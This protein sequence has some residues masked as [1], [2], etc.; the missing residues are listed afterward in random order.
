MK[1]IDNIIL[2]SLNLI[3]YDR[4]KH[5]T[6]Q[7]A[8]K[9]PGLNTLTLNPKT[10]RLEPIKS[11]FDTIIKTPSIDDF[12][13]SQQPK[14]EKIN[15]EDAIPYSTFK[16]VVNNKNIYLPS[17]IVKQ[18]GKTKF[19]TPNI[20]KKVTTSE[21]YDPKLAEEYFGSQ[22]SK[23]SGNHP[24]YN[25]G[26]YK[27]LDYYI[28]DS[29]NQCTPI[30]YK[31]ISKEVVKKGQKTPS[32][33][34]TDVWQNDLSKPVTLKNGSTIQKSKYKYP[35]GCKPIPY[36]TCLRYSWK[37]LHSFG[38]QNDGIL[39][40][41]KETYDVGS[42]KGSVGGFEPTRTNTTKI[43]YGACLSD[44]WFPWLSN[45]VGYLP[46][47]QI[48][49]QTDSAGKKQITKCIRR[50]YSTTGV[51]LVE[52]NLKSYNLSS[53]VGTLLP[54]PYDNVLQFPLDLAV[55]ESTG[56]AYKINA[57]YIDYTIDLNQWF[58]WG[59]ADYKT[60]KV[61]ANIDFQEYLNKGGSEKDIYDDYLKDLYGDS[62]THKFFGLNFNLSGK[63][64]LGIDGL[65]KMIND[66][67]TVDGLESKYKDVSERFI[68]KEDYVGYLAQLSTDYNTEKAKPRP[69]EV[70][71][72]FL[73]LQWNT[74]LSII[75]M[76]LV[77]PIYKRL[78]PDATIDEFT[79]SYLSY[80]FGIISDDNAAKESVKTSRTAPSALSKATIGINK[81]L[82]PSNDSETA[83]TNDYY[84][85]F[86][87]NEKGIWE[88]IKKY[89][90]MV[91]S[92]YAQYN[93]KNVKPVT[94][95]D[96]KD[97][98]KSDGK[99]NGYLWNTQTVQDIQAG[100]PVEMNNF[101]YKSLYSDGSQSQSSGSGE[102]SDEDIQTMIDAYESFDKQIE[103]IIK[104]TIVLMG[105]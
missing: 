30:P 3:S 104:N 25:V 4:S 79:I 19:V 81:Q 22:C 59:N 24:K 56:S 21:S 80:L 40:F 70:V 55:K 72:S 37:N 96:A 66:E 100:T 9:Y 2:K 5:V 58:V 87:M 23:L 86:L 105:R 94:I 50:N 95:L 32:V 46:K 39:E 52:N 65:E 90:L 15:D 47:T 88:T 53:G 11:P 61:D 91:P 82:N 57:N 10:G 78:V 35:Q 99:T 69:N 12:I 101:L 34:E 92:D 71:T 14:R 102:L 18:K 45:F 17:R 98:A 67:K 20:I 27:Q 43:S 36:D 83:K 76:S 28:D 68:G 13:K 49:V 33:I 75:R 85:S 7:V 54:V 89:P 97:R 8:P 29:G 16:S 1:D 48:K 51:D 93:K 26:Y 63:E 73:E 77:Y 44:D 6:E 74:T 42:S 31:V 103:S 60:Y 38:A 41:E 62:E 64:V 84:A